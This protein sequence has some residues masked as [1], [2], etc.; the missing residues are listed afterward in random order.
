MGKTKTVEIL[1]NKH[2]TDKLEE[3]EII[4]AMTVADVQ[5]IAEQRLG[6]P[7]NHNEMYSVR[8]GVEWGMDNRD[9]LIKV[10]IDNLPQEK[11]EE[12]ENLEANR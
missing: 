12:N 9:D 4:F 10:A 3:D 7:L 1:R 11:D 2:L 8:K 5:C 6:R